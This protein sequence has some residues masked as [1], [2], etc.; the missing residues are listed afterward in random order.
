MGAMR[1]K[2]PRVVVTFAS[3][4][5]AMAMEARAAECG[6]PGRIVPVPQ[7]ISAGCG[8]AWCADVSERE[9]LVSALDEH[10]LAHE[11]VFDVMMY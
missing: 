2:T 9:Q 7:E 11:G 8:L 1:E 3:T 5:D 4:D 10:G 6:I